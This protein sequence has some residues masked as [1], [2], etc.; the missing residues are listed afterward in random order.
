MAVSP[1][2][3]VGVLVLTGSSGRIDAERCDLLAQHGVTALSIR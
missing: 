3:E 1:G 2:A